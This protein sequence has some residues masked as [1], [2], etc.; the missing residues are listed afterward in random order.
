MVPRSAI[1]GIDLE[2]DWEDILSELATSHHTRL[3]VYEGTLDNVV[4]ILHLRKVLN[5]SQ[6]PDFNKDSL[7]SVMREPYFVAEGTTVTQQLLNMQAEKRRFGLVV[8]EYGDIKGL[9]TMEE[10][11]EEIVGEF[12]TRAPGVKEE[13]VAQE[14]G[15][16]LIGGGANVRDINRQLNWELPVEGPKTLNGLILE[17]LEHIPEA[18]TSLMLAGHPVEVLQTRGTAVK[19]ARV[20]PRAIVEEAEE[21]E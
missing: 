13:I 16:Y 15:S 11:L 1:E 6:R 19:T 3:P 2:D 18:G 17:Y 10:I 14:D 7:R 12:T 21:E 20:M 8:D 5:L 4:G 9:V